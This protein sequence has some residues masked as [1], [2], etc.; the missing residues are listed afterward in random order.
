M[1][2]VQLVP[3]KDATRNSKK[4][5]RN[6]PYYVFKKPKYIFKSAVN[7]YAMHKSYNTKHEWFAA[8]K[9]IDANLETF[10][11]LTVMI[12]FMVLLFL[13]A[14]LQH[15][16]V[17]CHKPLRLCVLLYLVKC[18]LYAH[19]EEQVVNRHKLGLNSMKTAQVFGMRL[20]PC[21]M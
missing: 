3:K 10:F 18:L 20:N 14:L 1:A 12:Q 11:L 19:S 6:L 21:A 7:P 9:L 13:S 15:P 17:V 5:I 8:I 4:R 16:D 2:E